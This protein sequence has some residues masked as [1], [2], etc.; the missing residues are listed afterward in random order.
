V[1]SFEE[2]KEE[3]ELC[4]RPETAP[5][6]I[7]SVVKKKE[8]KTFAKLSFFLSFFRQRKGEF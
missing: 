1:F 5:L 7:S 8:E 6:K 3:G 2:G 4:L